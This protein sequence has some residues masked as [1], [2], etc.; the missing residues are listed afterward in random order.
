MYSTYGDCLHG[1][2]RSRFAYRPDGFAETTS[3]GVLSIWPPNYSYGVHPNGKD[4]VRWRPELR[5][6]LSSNTRCSVRCAHNVKV[7]KK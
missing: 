1:Q 4:P 3:S 7:D 5:L 2:A 6:L